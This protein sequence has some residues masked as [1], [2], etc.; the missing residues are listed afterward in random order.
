VDAILTNRNVVPARRQAMVSLSL[1]LVLVTACLATDLL[2]QNRRLEHWLMAKNLNYSEINHTGFSN[3]GNFID[4][5]ERLLLDE[6]PRAD[7][8]HGGVYFFGTSNMKWAF[9]TFDLPPEQRHWIGNYGIGASNHTTVLRFIRYLI[10]Q[11]GFLRAGDANLVI[12][13]V[14]FHLG[15][16]DGQNDFFPSLLHRRGLFTIS[17]D[18]RM[19]PV[20]MN[21]IEQWLR[22]EKA[23]IGGFVWNYGRLLKN[24]LKSFDGSSRPIVHNESLYQEYW[25]SIMGAHWRKSVDTQVNQLRDTISLLRSKHAQVKVMLLPQATWMNTLPFKTHYETLVRAL[26]QET[27][28]PLIDFSHAMPDQAF[29]DS[30]HLTVEGQIKFRKL[31]MREITGHLQKLMKGE[32]SRTSQSVPSAY[33]ISLAPL[34]G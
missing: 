30:N 14:S 11:R 34:A 31:I 4:F 19:M 33:S 21:P 10:E 13:G 16:E 28:T 7:Y 15:I 25:R 5:E 24:S 27:S 23:R 18:G 3:T 12:L 29:V 22:V 6:L 32:S 2:A 8:S 1:L 26:C 20:P 17:A 9:T